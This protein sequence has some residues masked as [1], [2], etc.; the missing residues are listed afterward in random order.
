MAMTK[1][2]W[3][4]PAAAGA[5]LVVTATVSGITAAGQAEIL[6]AQDAQVASINAKTDDARAAAAA[7]DDEVALQGTG[8]SAERVAS[9]RDIVV[10]IAKRALTWDDDA[11]YRDARASTM[12]SYG[13]TE[14]STFMTSFLPDAPV[15]RDSQGNEYPY[16]DAAG[17]NSTVGDTVV[18]VLDVDGL[19]YSYLALVDV[20][21]S[22]SDGLATASSVATIFVTIDGDGAVSDLT[23][24][25]ST[26]T[27][28]TSG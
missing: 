23:G 22:S 11:T 16:I 12:R 8:A 20:Q 15:N 21:A 13:L 17:L 28:V 2:N 27:P 3:I 7:V 10:E 4:F 6:E 26:S 1:K 24:Y 9:D 5:L 19:D 18:K 25:A 14:D